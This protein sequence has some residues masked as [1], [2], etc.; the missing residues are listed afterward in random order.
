M[1]IG[2]RAPMGWVGP[3]GPVLKVGGSPGGLAAALGPG[4]GL[5]PAGVSGTSGVARLSW[6]ADGSGLCSEM[7]TEP[8]TLALLWGRRGLT[9]MGG[10]GEASAGA[11]GPEVGAA[12]SGAVALDVEDSAGS[13]ALP[14]CS[15]LW[16]WFSG[17]IF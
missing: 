17:S 11:A 6:A 8:S 7:S 9:G 15:S 14:D 13:T 3:L 12:A 1:E 4:F 2:L 10:R 16:F 5:K